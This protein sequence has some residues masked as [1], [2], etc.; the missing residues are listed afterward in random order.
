MLRT[1]IAAAIGCAR[2]NALDGIIRQ[3][4]QGHSSGALCDEDASHLSALAH[5]RRLA[6]QGRPQRVLGGLVL[7]AGAPRADAL[8]A[9]APVRRHS[10]FKG[11][12]EGRV[13]RP[14][15]RQETQKILLAAKRYELAERQRG[16]RS[17]PLGAVALEVLEYF[18]NLVDFRTGR[19]EPSLDTIMLK[20]RRSRDAVVRGLKAL[21]EH[22]FL[23]W[24]R[25]YEPTGHEGRGPQVRQVS[26][27]YRL[28]LPQKALRLL[29][30]FG[31]APPLPDDEIQARNDRAA[32]LAAQRA[33]LSFEDRLTLDLG[34]TMLAKAL[35]GLGQLVGKRESARQ[36]ESQ[37]LYLSYGKTRENG[38]LPAS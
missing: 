28:S 37:S 14:T 6:L 9:P 22:G 23:D 21:R 12:A 24:L 34:D 10:H 16:K 17:G 19:L 20:V 2:A 4:W 15:N 27:A 5:E 11:R 26:N 31:K 33:G 29:E 30:R 18:V 13:W 1:H 36:T 25:R 7:P 35:S 32:A 3:I 8:L 38:P